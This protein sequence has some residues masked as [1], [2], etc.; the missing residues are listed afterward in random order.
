MRRAVV[1]TVP[2]LLVLF[3]SLAEAAL[4][5]D[6][7]LLLRRSD[8]AR[9]G[10]D[11]FVARV[12]IVEYEQGRASEEHLFEVSQK[13]ADKSYV[14]FLSP[15]D[16]GRHMLMLGDEMWVFLPDTTRP[17]R[18]TP[19]ERL[20]GG[21]ANGDVAR[22]RYA[23]DYDARYL[24]SEPAEGVPCH[25]LELLAR[26]KGATYR[27]VL[28]WVR[29]EDAQPVKAEFF[30]ASG[31]HTKSAR[32]DE[33]QTLGGE[34]VLRRMTIRDEIRKGSTT[35]IEYLGLTPKAL[36]DKLF[37]QGRVERF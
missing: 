18:I 7:A 13:G 25:L 28:Y 23:E 20:A 24:R 8:H 11:S 31:K 21:A 30:L 10:W 6:P 26:R 36:P 4:P 3:A 2:P 1:R 14:E 19:T 34:R 32:F 9:N 37:H 29:S 16:K 33:Y 12:K 17:I 27:R 5:P 22:T 35:V 15:R